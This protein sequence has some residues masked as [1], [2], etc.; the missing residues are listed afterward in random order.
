MTLDITKQMILAQLQENTGRNLC[1]SGD[2]YGRHWQRNQ[3][4]TWEDFTKTPVSVAAH[5]Y[6]HNSEP[7]LE[8]VGIVSL[9]AYLYNNLTY[10]PPLQACYEAYA[11]KNSEEYDMT[12]MAEFAN[13][14]GDEVGQVCYT[15]N[16]DNCL[17]QDIQ[18]IQFKFGDEVCVLLQVHGGCDA[19]G[20]MSTPKA[21]VLRDRLEGYLPSS[22]IDSWGCGD[23]NWE[24][25][26]TPTDDSSGLN[27]FKDLTYVE[28]DWKAQS[29]LKRDLEANSDEETQAKLVA[30]DA[31]LKQEAFDAASEDFDV[32]VMDRKAYMAGEAI[33][34]MSYSLEG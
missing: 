4:K 1:D 7:E 23:Q 16:E 22:N 31:R 33:E 27:L 26:G 34:G 29:T 20:G 28:L 10:S 32:V 9:A 3:G 17:S 12:N 8:L 18:Y 25:D 21:Y 11:A 30:E 13:K 24:T 15:Y 19:R 2:H 5:I 14:N 6:A